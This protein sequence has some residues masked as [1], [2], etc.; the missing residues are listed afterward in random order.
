M[1]VF[2]E[3]LRDLLDEADH[4]SI[5]IERSRINWDTGEQ[6]Q[7]G[8]VFHKGDD[9]F[10][11]NDEKL[12]TRIVRSKYVEVV[13]SWSDGGAAILNL[14]SRDWRAINRSPSLKKNIERFEKKIK[15]GAASRFLTAGFALFLAMLPILTYIALATLALLLGPAGRAYLVSNSSAGTPS[16]PAPAWFVEITPVIFISWPFA[17]AIAT[18]IQIL[19]SKSGGLRIRPNIEAH[20]SLL[21]LIYRLRTEG[22]RV[23]NWRQIGTGIIIAII[24]ALATYLL[25]NK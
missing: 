4:W 8:L 13:L 12:D 2:Q 22:L 25:A 21:A 24:S 23:E 20:L 19:R 10:T 5:F 18:G 6:Q 9:D 1:E 3:A 16:P 7:R 14:T 17:I 11:L 15:E